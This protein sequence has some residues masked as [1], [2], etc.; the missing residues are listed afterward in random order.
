MASRKVLGNDPIKR[1]AAVRAPSAG[2]PPPKK[3]R[4]AR[5]QIAED[6]EPATLPSRRPSRS[7][8]PRAEAPTAPFQPVAHPASPSTTT[9]FL[10]SEPRPHAESP[11]ITV[12]PVHHTASPSLV[13]EVRAT[14]EPTRRSGSGSPQGGLASEA[15]RDSHPTA[16]TSS[17]EGPLAP[18]A[19]PEMAAVSPPPSSPM[20]TEPKAP[21]SRDLAGS[22]LAAHVAPAS[23]GGAI[24]G[25]FHAASALLRPREAARPVDT[26]GKDIELS[27]ALKPLG[28]LL[29]ERYW[30]VKTKGIENVPGGSCVLVANHAGALPLD[31][32]ILHLALRRERPDLADSRWLLED[33]VFSA[34]LIGP[35]ANRLGAVRATPEN[36]HRL[37]A[38]GHPLIVF[39]EGLAGPGKPFSERYQLQRFGRGGYLKVALR[40]HVPIVPVAIIGSEESSPLLGTLPLRALGFDRLPITLPPLPARWQIEFGVPIDLSDAPAVPDA[41]PAWIEEKNLMVRERLSAMLAALLEARDGVFE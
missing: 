24:R 14:V 36:A 22:A 3:K 31:G 19:S 40:A 34:P 20:P 28:E 18:S 21:L 30:R 27:R 9:V 29:Y 26:W 4:A 10:A 37:L 5:G 41:D 6:K 12:D 1:K 11:A 25:L 33:Q 13:S 16:A 7:S 32:P 2:P 8:E 23:L 15:L 39:P 17:V 38:E 35:L